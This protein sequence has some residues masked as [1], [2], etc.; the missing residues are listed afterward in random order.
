MTHDY[1]EGFDYC[2]FSFFTLVGRDG[3]SI[4]D[5]ILNRRRVF[6]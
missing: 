1:D 2:L 5:P 6:H 3:G 4:I